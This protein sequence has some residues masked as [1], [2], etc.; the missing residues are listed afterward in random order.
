[1]LILLLIS[2]LASLTVSFVLGLRLLRLASRTRELPEVLMGSAFLLAGV[3]GY[4]LM[5]IGAGGAKAMPPATAESFFFAGYALI[6]IGVVLTY[7][8]IWRVFRPRSG[9]S[10]VC[11]ILA[12]IATLVTAHPIALPGM[13][14]EG[15]EIPGILGS[16]LFWLGHALR[17][18]VGLWGT[19]EAGSYYLTLRRRLRLGLA[20]PVVANR[21]LLWTIASVGGAAIFLSTAVSNATGSDMEEVMGTSQILVISTV[22]F[23]VA[24]CQ[25]FAFL[26][27]DRYRAW[28]ARRAEP[29]AS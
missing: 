12:A 16:A 29:A 2:T 3:V 5:L 14:Q 26:P 28:L 1:M 21:I 11:V 7:L 17:V 19:I 9:L 25:W 8:F 20:D 23:L 13:Q 6:S 27:P 18:G 24:G 15:F 10:R 4:I 22:T